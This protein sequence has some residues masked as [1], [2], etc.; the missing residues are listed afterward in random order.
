MSLCADQEQKKIC[1]EVRTK[2]IGDFV[3]IVEQMKIHIDLKYNEYMDK[4]RDMLV[5]EAVRGIK[6]FMK[7]I[8]GSDYNIDDLTKAMMVGDK[9]SMSYI[10]GKHKSK[11]VYTLL[12]DNGRI[13]GGTNTSEKGYFVERQSDVWNHYISLYGV[14]EKT[15]DILYNINRIIPLNSYLCKA[16]FIRDIMN[17]SIN[18]IHRSLIDEFI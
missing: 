16:I 4:N 9:H 1:D 12:Y 15:A 8:G 10:A 18:G 14:D 17:S 5:A 7:I 2:F 3:S 6:Y 13:I 11:P